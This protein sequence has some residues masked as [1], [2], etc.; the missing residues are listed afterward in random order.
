M[1]G[2]KK[3]RVAVVTGTRAE[4][5]LLRP[6]CQKL[7]ASDEL[8]LEL[9]VTGAHLS[10]KYGGTVAEIEADGMPIAAR[11]PILN[12]PSTDLGTCLTIGD[13]VGRF[14]EQFSASRPDCVLVL[15]DRYEIFAAATAAAVLRIPLAHISGGD[16]TAGAADE[17][18]RHSITK[19][20]SVHFPVSYTHLDVYKRQALQRGAQCVELRR[21]GRAARCCLLYTSHRRTTENT[22]ESSASINEASSCLLYAS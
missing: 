14:A 4:Y 20:A 9:V 17:F 18:F 13:A 19:M 10:E 21:R 6:V 3:R 2:A 11:I 8:E 16:V 5:G 15:G 12:H 7:L 1:S 22:R